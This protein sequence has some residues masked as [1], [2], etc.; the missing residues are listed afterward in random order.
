MQSFPLTGNLLYWVIAW[1]LLLSLLCFILYALDK[2]AAV[3]GR[4]RIS[5][6]SLIF[7]GLL[8]G[9]PGSLLAQRLLRHKTKK[10]AFLIPFWMSVILNLLVLILLFFPSVL[11]QK[12][13]KFVWL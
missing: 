2:S 10:W 9:W 11:L 12:I 4:R 3:A 6:K 1:Y 8:G 7:W 5:E 13:P